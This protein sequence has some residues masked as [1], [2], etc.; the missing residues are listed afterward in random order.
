[1]DSELVQ[2]AKN[3]TYILQSAEQGNA[4]FLHQTPEVQQKMKDVGVMH[5]DGDIDQLKKEREVPEEE[6]RQKF[7]CGC[8]C[9]LEVCHI[10]THEL[11]PTVE[12]TLYL[13]LCV[14]VCSQG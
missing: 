8:W 6:D 1:M 13:S 5:T 10:N 9:P 11:V 12:I 3:E 4:L 7:P 14:C 2:R